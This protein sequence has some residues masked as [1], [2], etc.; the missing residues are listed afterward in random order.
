MLL[1]SSTILTNAFIY[2]RF[3]RRSEVDDTNEME[4]L[5][6]YVSHSLSFVS[7]A[8]TPAQHGCEPTEDSIVPQPLRDYHVGTVLVTR[9]TVST[10]SPTRSISDSKDDLVES[11][12][13]LQG[14]VSPRQQ[15]GG[16]L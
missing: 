2:T 16:S 3:R 9:L 4:G 14:P 6:M 10:C 8:P 15:G 11:K 5:D 13:R 7:A 12:A 1:L